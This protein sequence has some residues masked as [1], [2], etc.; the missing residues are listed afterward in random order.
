L[1]SKSIF[2]KKAFVAAPFHLWLQAK[3]WSEPKIVMRF[4]ILSIIFAML[5]LWLALISK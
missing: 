3:G 5:G 1:L 2:G 4:W